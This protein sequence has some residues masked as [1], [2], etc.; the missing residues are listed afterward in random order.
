MTEKISKNSYYLPKN[1]MVFF[2]DWCFPSKNYSPKVA[3]AIL[4]F[5][6]LPASVREAAEKSAFETD[7]ENALKTIKKL[8]DDTAFRGRFEEAFAD[9]QKAL[10]QSGAGPGTRTAKRSPRE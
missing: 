2:R 7:I 8:H 6:S 3:G 5:M 1:L 10:E 9:F 4:F